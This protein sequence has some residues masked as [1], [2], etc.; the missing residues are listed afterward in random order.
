MKSH[1]EI[2]LKVYEEIS[3]ELIHRPAFM[4]N[5]GVTFFQYGRYAE[6]V[7]IFEDL[8][9]KFVTL[10]GMLYLG[11]SYRAVKQ[12]NDAEKIFKDASFMV[13]NRLIPKYDL[14]MLYHEIGD[15][16]KADAVGK[17]ILNMPVKIPSNKVDSMK[18]E[19]K[20]CL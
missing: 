13:P 1:P 12:Y 10:D 15:S 5:Y 8:R 4:Y 20:K 7:K 6:S 9:N 17:E 3:K 16:K 18:N 19:I 11:K 14:F 2:S